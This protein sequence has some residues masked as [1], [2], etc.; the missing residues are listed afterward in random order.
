MRKHAFL[1]LMI[2]LSMLLGGVLV[3]AQAAPLTQPGLAPLPAL[4]GYSYSAGLVVRNNDTASLPA[5]YTV[6]FT[7]DTQALISAGR[8]QDDCDDLRISFTDVTENELDRLVTGCGTAATQVQFRTQASIA[9]GMTDERYTFNYGNAGAAS[10][11]QNPANVFYF[12][13]DFQDGDANG[14]TVTKGTWGMVN[15]AG[16]YMYR[17]T[18]GG[19]NWPLA[20]T[21]VPLSD[22]DYTARI[23]ATDS[24]KTDWIGLAFRILD[25]STIPDFLTFYQSR[26]T[27]NFKYGVIT[28][29]NHANPIASPGFTMPQNAWYRIRLQAVGSTVRARIWAD[30]AAEPATWMI[31]TTTTTYQSSTNIGLTLYFHTTNAD[32]DDIQ[33]RRL[34]AVEPSVSLGAAP[35]GIT[36]I[37]TAET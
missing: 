11:P 18:G 33:V 25:P 8:L 7:L 19:A 3:I 1:S 9:A 5:G 12:Y 34:V 28:N 17:Y 21:S 24:P 10:P 26:D 2:V 6:S 32:W 27:N 22:L 23:R 20:Y 16:N 14:W 35:G 30:G 37:P 13:D 29:D 15:D 31:S 36:L 4:P